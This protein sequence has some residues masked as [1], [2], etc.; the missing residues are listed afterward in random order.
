MRHLW[1]LVGSRAFSH[2]KIYIRR[3]HA[4]TLYGEMTYFERN[5]STEPFDRVNEKQEVIERIDA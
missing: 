1:Q 3:L 2:N 5:Q 4:T